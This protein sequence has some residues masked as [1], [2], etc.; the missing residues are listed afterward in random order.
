M[1]AAMVEII[2]PVIP[3]VVLSIHFNTLLFNLRVAMFTKR[4]PAKI[5]VPNAVFVIIEVFLSF[6]L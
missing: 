5:E 6:F 3:P 1:F 4:T 2:P